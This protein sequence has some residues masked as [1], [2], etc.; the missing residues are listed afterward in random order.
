MTTPQSDPS[1]SA[2][3]TEAGGKMSFFEHLVDLR[4]RLI[5]SAIAI[6]LGA[7]IGVSIADK[8]FGFIARPMQA[9]LQKQHLDDRL[10]YTSPTGAINLI[11]TLGIYIGVVMASPVVLYQ[12]WLFIAPGLY[13]HE[14]RAVTSFI[15]FSLF[16]FLA[17]ISFGYFIM[18]P[19]MLNFLIGFQ[20][21]FRPLISINEY[22]DFILIVLLGLGVIF[23]LPVLIFF[24]A[25]FNIVTPKFLWKNLRY[26]ILIIAVVAAI[27]TP[28]PD[29]TTMLV[30][31][32]PMIALY[33]IGI[34]VAALVVRNK[35]KAK[36]AAT[37]T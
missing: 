37:A 1:T 30:F 23:E 15:F 24:L 20:G 36:Q 4:K 31:M 2:P 14:R 10:V 34:G 9:A 13:K 16:L 19:Y 3:E 8:V 21:P 12:V 22:F 32:A 25:L 26:A 17:G 28:T 33:F 27:I 29:A 18:L 7:G 11:I 35:N 5:N 6:A